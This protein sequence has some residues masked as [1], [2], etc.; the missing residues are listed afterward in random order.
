[1]EYRIVRWADGKMEV[2]IIGKDGLWHH[3]ELRAGSRW[4]LWME[5]VR[6]ITAFGKPELTEKSLCEQIRAVSVP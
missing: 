2:V 3:P 5:A 1:M 6:I 4:N